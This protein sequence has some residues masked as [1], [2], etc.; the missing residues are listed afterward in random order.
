MLSDQSLFEVVSRAML[1]LGGFLGFLMALLLVLG[2]LSSFLD[3][4]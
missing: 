3:T 2:F 1:S 4:D